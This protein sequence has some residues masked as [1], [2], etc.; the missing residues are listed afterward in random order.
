M[1]VIIRVLAKRRSPYTAIASVA[2]RST[3]PRYN[4]ATGGSI[5]SVFRKVTKLGFLRI[6]AG[7]RQADS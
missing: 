1:L 4:I 6:A 3:I 7:V 2:Q 5:S